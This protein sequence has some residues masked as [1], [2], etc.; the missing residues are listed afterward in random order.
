[1]YAHA[2]ARLPFPL[3]GT[4]ADL[5][6]VDTGAGTLVALHTPGHAD[7]HLAYQLEG[8]GE[9]ICGDL[10]AGVGTIVLVPPE[11][12]LAAYL[13]S[14]ARV[15]ALAT[16]LWPAHG[17]PQPAALADQYIAHRHLRT[18][19]FR[20]VL[21][22]QGPCTPEAIAAAVYAAVPGANVFLAALQVRTHLAWLAAGGEVVAEGDT[23][24]LA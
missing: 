2:D 13:A 9:V 15:R 16:Q 4:L 8:T 12:D 14:L 11:G 18:E 20:A 19:Q 6:R 24:R 5:D 23:W 17:P 21:H 22:A 3:A 1:V 7:G 10:V